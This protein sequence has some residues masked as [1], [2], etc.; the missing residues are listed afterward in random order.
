MDAANSNTS[1][2]TDDT[3]LLRGLEELNIPD[4]PDTAQ[5][6]SAYI[7]EIEL[8]NSAYDLTGAA[9]HEDIVVRHIL[10]SLAPY[11]EIAQLISG[12]KKYA[13]Q[14]LKSAENVTTEHAAQNSAAQHIETTPIIADIGSG[15]GLP[16][17]PLAICFPECRFFLVERMSKRCSFLENCIAVLGLKNTVVRNMQAERIPQNSFNIVVF[18]AFRPLDKKI[19]RILLRTLA[20]N[21]Y[22]AAYKAK[23]EK[24]HAEMTA[25]SAQIPEWECRKIHVPFLPDAERH[26]VIIPAAKKQ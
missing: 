18:R 20:P 23:T 1:V 26:L 9:T 12:Q 13:A 14:T 7:H 16:G 11:S 2:H 19:T 22:L 21:G 17:I 6:L 25:I 15:A 4:I 8:F 5:K 10:D 24:I 3:T